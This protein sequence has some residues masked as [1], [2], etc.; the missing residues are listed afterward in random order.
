MSGKSDIIDI[1]GELRHET[2]KAYLIFDGTTEVWLPKS[3]VEHDPDNGT[4]AMPEWMA[5][6][7]GLI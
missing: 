1:A 2:P 6:A 3:H 4:F 7:K 5:K